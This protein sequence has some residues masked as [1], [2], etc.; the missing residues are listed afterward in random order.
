V[1]HVS[2]RIWRCFWIAAAIGVALVSA[3][4]SFG[5]EVVPNTTDQA[6]TALARSLV[7]PISKV[8]A[9]SILVLDLRDP[10]GHSHPIGK[11]M[12]ER[13]SL[14]IQKEL[15]NVQVIDRTQLISQS[16]FLGDPMDDTAIF[17]HDVKIAHALKADVFIMGDFAGAAGQIGVSLEIVKLSQLDRPRVDRTALIPL[18]KEIS[19][20]TTDSIPPLKLEDGIPRGGKGGISSPVCIRCPKPVPVGHESGLVKVKLIVTRDGRPQSIKL[21]E[22]P[23]N[24]LTAATIRAIQSWTFKPAIGYEGQ[25]ID[26]VV[27]VEIDFRTYQ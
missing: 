4:S 21:I 25:P 9:K 27:P 6:I 2:S 17:R 20:L 11:W 5:Q 8:K 23:S 15:P 19:D 12:S 16:A 26:V 24:D 13:L 1:S 18:S 7:E 14:T 10:N 3:E 22:S